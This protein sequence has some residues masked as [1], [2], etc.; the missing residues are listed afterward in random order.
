MAMYLEVDGQRVGEVEGFKLDEPPR[1]QHWGP[2]WPHLRV[3]PPN[4]CSFT[5]KGVP[6]QQGMWIN[7]VDD[8]GTPIHELQLLHIDTRMGLGSSTST[9]KAKIL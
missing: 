6:P 4:T 3:P 8:D 7:V 9:V 2:V 5:I 1:I